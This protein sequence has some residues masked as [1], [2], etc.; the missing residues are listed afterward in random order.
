MDQYFLYLDIRCIQK[1]VK[2][3][4]MYKLIFIQYFYTVF[5]TVNFYIL[6]LHHFSPVIFY[7]LIS[8]IT[9]RQHLLQIFLHYQIQN[10]PYLLM[11]NRF[12]CCNY[13][14]FLSLSS[15]ILYYRNSFHKFSIIMYWHFQIV[16]LEY[17]SMHQ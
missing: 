11:P 14:P 8:T 16:L 13:L 10:V 17:T 1:T 12:E 5:Y 4:Y 15:R 2:I 9:S 3:H 6:F 7:K